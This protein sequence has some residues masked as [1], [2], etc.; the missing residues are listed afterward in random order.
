M[1]ASNAK[2]YPLSWGFIGIVENKVDKI[3]YFPTSFNI[4]QKSINKDSASMA[5]LILTKYLNK[6]KLIVGLHHFLTFRQ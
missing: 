2:A 6:K 3:N 5:A 4:F 1:V